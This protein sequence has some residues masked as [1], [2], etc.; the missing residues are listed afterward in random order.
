MSARNRS[1]G[2]I[3]VGLETI[4]SL[5]TSAVIFESLPIIVAQESCMIGPLVQWP[6]TSQDVVKRIFGESLHWRSS[7]SLSVSVG[8]A[9]VKWSIV[10]E[11]CK[12][13]SNVVQ[14]PIS[15][16]TSS[17]INTRNIKFVNNIQLAIWLLALPIFGI[18]LTVSTLSSPSLCPLFLFFGV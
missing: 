6:S 8:V 15:I 13:I 4:A 3:V 11:Y 7:T 14:T 17:A 18:T 9:G 1:Y 16:L 10:V 5:H 2:T 12:N